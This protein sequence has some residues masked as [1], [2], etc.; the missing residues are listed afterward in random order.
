M[1]FDKNKQDSFTFI[2]TGDL[3]LDSP[4]RGMS[5]INTELSKKLVEST[6]QAY[7]KIIDTCINR[8]PQNSCSKKSSLIPLLN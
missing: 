8:L 6:F 4:F 2:H 7:N 5:E 3:H 1:N